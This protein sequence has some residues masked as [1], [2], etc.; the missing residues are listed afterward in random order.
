ME[1]SYLYMGLIGVTYTN[2]ETVGSRY[3]KGFFKFYPGMSF[4][5]LK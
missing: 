5:L 3:A 2:P 1:T 4:K